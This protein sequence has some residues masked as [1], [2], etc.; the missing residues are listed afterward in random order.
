MLSRP[1]QKPKP[2]VA[3]SI[4]EIGA[5]YIIADAQPYGGKYN[6]YGIKLFAGTRFI[7]E[8]CHTGKFWSVLVWGVRHYLPA[9]KIHKKCREI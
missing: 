9:W 1:R 5:E 2:I 6:Q 8:K 3:G 7:I 4:W